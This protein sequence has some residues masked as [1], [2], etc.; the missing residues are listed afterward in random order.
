[1]IKTRSDEYCEEAGRLIPGGVNSPVRAFMSVHDRPFFVKRAKGSRLYD[2]D[3]NAF[4]DYVASWGAII[5]GH[6]DEGLIAAVTEALE[7]GTSYGACHPYE[8][9][10]ARLITEAFP[11]IDLLR[12]TTSGTEA[13]MSALRLARGYTGKNGVIKFRGCY[14]GHVDSLLVK[15]GSGLATFGIPDSAGVPADLAKHTY[16]ADF[17][18]IETVEHV[19]E[20]NDD[21]A[22]VIVEPIMGNMGVI[23]P[24]E[25]FLKDL[26]SLCRKRGVLLI[27]DEVISGFRVAFGGAQHIY[28]IDPDITCLGKIIGGGFPIGAFGG[29]RHIMERL[30][31]LGDVYQAGTLSGNPVAVRA[32]LHV[33]RG[34]RSASGEVYPRLESAGRTLSNA[35]VSIAGRYGIPYRVNSTTGMFTG[36][37]SEAPVTDYDSA[38]ASD[39]NLYER[40]FKAMLDEGV[41]FAPSQFEAS[42]VTLTLGQA[43]IE[44][45]VAAC[46]KVFRD[47]GSARQK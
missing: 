43:E 40:F 46:E 10:L 2:V 18:R 8:L 37:F 26:E 25:G 13:T 36:F 23:L 6:A 42:F 27:F 45:T 5:L 11:S 31:P 41:F 47:I 20:G 24:G 44:R 7:E 33:L 1:M 29:K 9:E 30:A 39:R 28:G 32:G 16:V 38:A 21:I 15:A 17:N 22:C 34:L 12:L 35:M 14:H 4:I 19:M 3:G